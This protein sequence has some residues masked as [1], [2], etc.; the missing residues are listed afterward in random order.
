MLP[1]WQWQ[2]DGDILQDSMS[3]YSETPGERKNM[4]KEEKEKHLTEIRKWI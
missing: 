2:E 3:I 4:T 1:N